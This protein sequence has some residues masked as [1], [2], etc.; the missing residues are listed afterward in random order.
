MYVAYCNEEWSKPFRGDNALLSFSVLRRSRAG[1]NCLTV[2]KK[3]DGCREA[4]DGFDIAHVAVYDGDDVF[5][6]VAN[7]IAILAVVFF[8]RFACFCRFAIL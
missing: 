2:F 3:Q 6:F 7:K 8:T 5:L 1:L 4:F